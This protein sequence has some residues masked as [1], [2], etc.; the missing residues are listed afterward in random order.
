M[1]RHRRN[2]ARRFEFRGLLSATVSSRKPR[3]CAPQGATAARCGFDRYR[4]YWYVHGCSTEHRKSSHR[5]TRAVAG[6]SGFVPSGWRANRSTLFG[7][8]EPPRSVRWCQRRCDQRRLDPGSRRLQRG[9][10]P[11]LTGGGRDLE[12]VQPPAGG[13]KCSLRPSRPARPGLRGRTDRL[14]AVNAARSWQRPTSAC[15]RPGK[16]RPGLTLNVSVGS[17]FG[18]SRSTRRCASTA[19]VSGR[20]S[21]HGRLPAARV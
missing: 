8:R 9:C 5:D 20:A 4:A 1:G 12:C 14:T 2:A 18:S 7:A 3:Q 10:S 21:A 16:K 6:H 15:H 17:S 11:S 19:A 13:Q